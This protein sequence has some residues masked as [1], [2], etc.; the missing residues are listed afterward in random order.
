ML[1]P[2]LLIV[3]QKLG[4]LGVGGSAIAEQ[5]EKAIGIDWFGHAGHERLNLGSSPLRKRCGKLLRRGHPFTRAIQK[6]SRANARASVGSVLFV[7]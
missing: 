5:C 4:E 6:I 7:L 2:L 3:I 1:R